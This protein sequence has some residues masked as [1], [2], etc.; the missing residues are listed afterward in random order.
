MYVILELYQKFE[1]PTLLISVLFTTFLSKFKV[2][3][4]SGLE[5]RPIAKNSSEHSWLIIGQYGLSKS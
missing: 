1:P 5:T 2:Q 3:L 4:R